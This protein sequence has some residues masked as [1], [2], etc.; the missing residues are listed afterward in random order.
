MPGKVFALAKEF[1]TA[2]IPDEIFTE[3]LTLQEVAVY[4][5]SL[6]DS[7]GPLKVRR[8]VLLFGREVLQLFL[9]L[10]L[11]LVCLQTSFEVPWAPSAGQ[12]VMRGDGADRSN[13]I[14]TK[15]A[16]NLGS[17]YEGLCMA[18]YLHYHFGRVVES[19]SRSSLHIPWDEGFLSCLSSLTKQFS[20][21]SLTI[22]RTV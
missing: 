13:A 22:G 18:N 20:S 11:F 2:V 4:L 3:R 7:Y 14:W 1:A 15:T 10:S 19:V 5:E 8:T 12:L 17:E 21:R 6:D 16:L 9:H